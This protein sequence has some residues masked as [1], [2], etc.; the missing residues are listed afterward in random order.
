MPPKQIDISIQD[1]PAYAIADAAAYLGLPVATV[2]SWVKG[3]DYKVRGEVR[4]YRPLIIPADRAKGLL[5]FRNL[6]ELHVLSVTRRM[7]GISMPRMR[8]AISYL[9]RAFDT[10]HPLADVSIKTDGVSIFVDQ[11]QQLVSASEDGQTSIREIVDHYLQ[12]V[13]R[14]KQGNLWLYPFTRAS[15]QVE[16][17]RIVVMDPRVSF[18]RPVIAET[19]IRTSILAERYRAGESIPELMADYGLDQTVIEEAIRC[20]MRKA[21]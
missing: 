5:S 21:A 14:D 6:V 10:E 16:Q 15:D 7:H 12:R 17:P 3:Y 18:G 13:G 1:M 4:K 2:R 9:K 11:L 20:E 19:G 8:T